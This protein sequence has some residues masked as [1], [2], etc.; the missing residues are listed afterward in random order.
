MGKPTSW[1]FQQLQVPL[2]R[3]GQM[4]DILARELR[5]P[6]QS[7]LDVQPLRV[8]LDSRK[9]GHPQWICN[10]RF[11]CDQTLR[12]P[13]LKP[14][15]TP[16]ETLNDI[17]GRDSLD[18][19]MQV[20]IVGAGPAGLWAA[21]SLARKGY[22]V[23]LHEQGQ[24]VE[25]RFRDIRHFLKG[26]DFNAR[27]NIL[28]GEGGAGAF[29]DGKLTSRTRTP[30]VEQ[31]LNDLALAGAGPEVRWLAKP[32]I[33]TDRLQ[34]ILLQVRHWIEEA[35]GKVF[36]D[37][38]LTD[39]EIQE[40]A[41]SRVAFNNRWQECSSLVLATGHS[42]RDVYSLLQQRGVTVQAKSYALG[43]RIEH[44]QA[45]INERQLGQGVDTRLTGAAEYALTAST[46][47][48]S[49]NAYSFCMCPG[50]VLIPCTSEPGTLATNGMSYSRRNA[51]FANAGIVVPVAQE[52]QWWLNPLWKGWVDAGLRL[53]ENPEIWAG[54]ALQ[55]ALESEAFSRGGGNY[56]APAQ[57]A[58]KF[59]D[60]KTDFVLP[61][62]SYPLGLIPTNHWDWLPRPVCQSIAEGF[63]NFERK[64]PGWIRN[65]LLVSPETRTSSPLRIPRNNNLESIH[66]RGLFPLGE[67]AGY[68]GGITTSAAD[69]VHL[70]VL[71]RPI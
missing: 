31:V 57:T 4:S 25:E 8:S 1:I 5:I 10:V 3:R 7:L 66:V 46:C 52:E 71:A 21:L 49:S 22:R 30:F 42:A 54:I 6:R 34:K 68:A 19:G 23:E 44:P 9:K 55:R 43:V 50:G 45:F 41:V 20:C 38:K 59:L 48:G 61:K 63:L 62:S 35:G 56:A 36:F 15:N 47:A 65:G 13:Q 12:H 26:R 11:V 24:P 67:G 70:A 33:G 40:G 58:A 60:Q 28:F 27:S 64:I 17:P 16:I 51:P 29:S 32:H 2:A 69:G 53:H 39:L 18:L 14:D 37:S